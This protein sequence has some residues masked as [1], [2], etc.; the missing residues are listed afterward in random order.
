MLVALGYNVG[1][2]SASLTYPAWNGRAILLVDLD[3]FF[4]SVEQ[5]DHPAW[6]GKP[7]IVGGDADKR[8]VVST[9]SYEARAYGVRSAMPAVMAVL[10]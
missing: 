8:G 10:V 1:M 4:A 2:D 7:V 9:C 3:A 5:L 6:R